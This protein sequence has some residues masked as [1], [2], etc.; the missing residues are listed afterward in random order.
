MSPKMPVQSLARQILSRQNS[1]SRTETGSN[2]GRDGFES[3]PFVTLMSTACSINGKPHSI[4]NRSQ[5]L[6]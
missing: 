2:V 6:S 3:R 1:F 4:V 5:S